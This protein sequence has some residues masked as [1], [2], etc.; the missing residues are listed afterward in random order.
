LKSEQ[1]TQ[2]SNYI[3]IK[4]RDG[5]IQSH[6][7]KRY[8]SLITELTNS[9]ASMYDDVDHMR[10][11]EL[12]SIGGSHMG[13]QVFAVFYEKVRNLKDYHSRYPDVEMDDPAMRFKFDEQEVLTKFR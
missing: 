10:Q 2:F 7:I 5:V 6:K 8:L 12:D 1:L 11:T 13:I 3:V 4:Y 9:L